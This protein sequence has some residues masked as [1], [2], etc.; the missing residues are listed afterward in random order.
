M[1]PQRHSFMLISF[2]FFCFLTCCR[3]RNVRSDLLPVMTSSTDNSHSKCH[4]G[5]R[6]GGAP[7][8]AGAGNG[9]HNLFATLCYFYRSSLH[10]CPN[11][12][13]QTELMEVDQTCMSPGTNT[14]TCWW[15]SD[16]GGPQVVVPL[17]C[18]FHSGAGGP[19]SQAGGPL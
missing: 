12:E 8:P 11:P 19:P 4:P 18:W 5:L 3:Q 16:A 15:P 14:Q 10:L 2:V 13:P 17:R 9:T 7:R 6:P 1:S